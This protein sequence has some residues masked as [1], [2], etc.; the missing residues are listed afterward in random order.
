MNLQKVKTPRGRFAPSPTGQL[1]VGNALSALVAWL[2]IRCQKGVFVYRVED[3]DQDRVL[4]DA[5]AGQMEDLKW[6]GIDWDEGPIRGGAFGPYKQSSR[7]DKY[8]RALQKLRLKDRIFP[9]RLSRK[10]LASISSAP[11]GVDAQYSPYPVSL[12]PTSLPP[13]WFHTISDT[14]IRFRVKQGSVAYQDLLFGLFEEDV[15][16]TCG[17][18]VVKRRDGMYAYQLAVVVDDIGMRISEVVR[19]ADLLTSTARQIQLFQALEAD[20]P[21]FGHV[22][23]VLNVADEKLSKR[24]KVMTLQSLRQAGVKPEQLI[25]FLGKSIGLIDS[26][27]NKTPADLIPLF[28]WDRVR[29]DNIRLPE[30]LSGFLK[31]NWN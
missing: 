20:V 7:G 14:N 25:G 18:F 12:R 1:H 6:L 21:L 26:V 11:H 29:K 3:I 8:E 24:D 16:Q 27:S 13:D 10:D 22:P 5:A 17:D 23:L 28:R 2:S 15:L 4:P 30:D 31:K 9:C 19:G